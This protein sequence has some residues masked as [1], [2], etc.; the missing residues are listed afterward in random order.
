MLTYG[1]CAVNIR[2]GPDSG[3]LRHDSGGQVRF[4]PTGGIKVFWLLPFR[5]PASASRSGE[6]GGASRIYMIFFNF[7]LSSCPPARPAAEG[8]YLFCRWNRG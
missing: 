3:I 1:A 5:L 7:W 6:A 8:K 2:L 4:A